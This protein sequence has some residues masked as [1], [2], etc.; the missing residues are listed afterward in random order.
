[1][2]RF[3]LEEI[4]LLKIDIEGAEKELFST[5]YESWLPKTK[6]L[7]IELHDRYRKG[8]A[9]SFFKAICQYDFSIFLGRENLIC[10]RN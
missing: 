10:I 3:Q 9:T 6:V 2:E 5:N 8:T 7:Y 4:D 1:M